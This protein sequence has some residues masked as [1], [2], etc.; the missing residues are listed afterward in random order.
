[1]GCRTNPH[2]AH[3]GVVVRVA[4]PSFPTPVTTSV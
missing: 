2:G 4:G 3:L 1:M